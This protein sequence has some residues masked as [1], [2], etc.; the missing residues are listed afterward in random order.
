MR[1]WFETV[2][3]LAAGADVLR[4]HRYGV[5]EVADG[6]LR[7]V[8]LRP[9]PKV[10]SFWEAWLARHA[11]LTRRSGNRCWLY[12]NQ[13]R[14]YPWCLTLQYIISSHDT[15]FHTFRLAVELLDEV[16]RIKRIDT[17]LCDVSN[18]RISDRLLE[19]WGWEPHAPMPWHRNYVKRLY[20]LP[21]PPRASADNESRGLL[22]GASTA[23]A[24]VAL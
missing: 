17:L 24:K 14:R 6:A 20:R 7:C 21:A 18:V 22:A 1:P 23:T 12:Y 15:T 19:R 3:D 2:T 5:I 10:A 16:A 11:R 9:F 13:P 8:R 4:T